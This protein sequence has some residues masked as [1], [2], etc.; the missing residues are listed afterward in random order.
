MA[1]RAVDVQDHVRAPPSLHRRRAL[2]WALVCKDFDFE[3]VAHYTSRLLPWHYSLSA[4]WVGQAGSLL[5]WTWLLML[6]SF[7]FYGVYPKQI[8]PRVGAFGV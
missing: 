6:L 3:Y 5:L 4:L 1:T 2:G 7:V 8:T